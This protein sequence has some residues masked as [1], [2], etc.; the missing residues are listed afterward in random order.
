MLICERLELDLKQFQTVDRSK[1]NE[2]LNRYYEALL[3]RREAVI[4]RTFSEIQ[5]EIP[6]FDFEQQ[7]LFKL[8][9]MNDLLRRDLMDKAQTVLRELEQYE[10]ALSEYQKYHYFKVKAI[11]LLKHKQLEECLIMFEQAEKRVKDVPAHEPDFYYYCAIAYSRTQQYFRSIDNL[12]KALEF[13]KKYI[14]VDSITNCH[15]LLGINYLLLHEYDFA[16]EQFN[17]TLDVSFTQN[18]PAMKAKI[19]HN[20]GYLKYKQG[21]FEK[22]IELLQEALNLKGYNKMSLNTLYLLAVSKMKVS[23]G[24]ISEEFNRGKL[25]AENERNLE[26]QY[27]FKIL[28][29]EMKGT[30]STKENV[31]FLVKEALPYYKS[32][33]DRDDYRDLICKIASVHEENGFYKNAAYYYKLCLTT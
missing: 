23:E 26:Y 22:S 17:I 3:F 11:Y 10:E 21:R 7:V 33:C 25:L 12:Q 1:F 18:K 32:N 5:E 6:Q 29:M 8:Y 16:E 27:K 14:Q 13:Y 30:L 4:Q 9:Y 20:L 28:E 31:Q 15:L 2:L 19:L 24:E